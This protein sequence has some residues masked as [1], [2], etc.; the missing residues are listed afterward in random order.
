MCPCR[1][2]HESKQLKRRFNRAALDIETYGSSINVNDN[3]ESLFV[4]A[5]R[6]IIE[7]KALRP[8]VGRLALKKKAKAEL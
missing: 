8:N 1:A 4:L 7:I 6:P 5:T 3:R 2:P